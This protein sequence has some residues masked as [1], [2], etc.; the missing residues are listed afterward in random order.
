MSKR[1]K[2]FRSLLALILVLASIL[3]YGTYALA[4]EEGLTEGQISTEDAQEILDDS[5]LVVTF[6]ELEALEALNQNNANQEQIEEIEDMCSRILYGDEAVE[7]AKKETEGKTKAL[8]KNLKDYVYLDFRIGSASRRYNWQVKSTQALTN[9]T[10]LKSRDRVFFNTNHQ[11]VLSAYLKGDSPY[12]AMPLSTTADAKALL[13]GYVLKNGDI[14]QMRIWSIGNGSTDFPGS[15]TDDSTLYINASGNA[16]SWKGAFTGKIPLTTA[17]QILTLNLNSSYVGQTLYGVCFRPVTKDGMVGDSSGY[18][19]RMNL[20]YI[21]VG[22]TKYKPVYIEYR[23]QGNVYFKNSDGSNLANEFCKGYIGYDE[24]P[25]PFNHGKSSTTTS[26][27]GWEIYEKNGSGTYE[28]QNVF[29]IDLTGYACEVD[30]Y[31]VLK[32]VQ[33]PS[34]KVSSSQSVS[35]DTTGEDKFVVSAAAVDS[36]DFTASGVGKP[37][38]ISIVLDRSARMETLYGTKEFTSKPSETEINNYMATLDK[39]KPEGY[40]RCRAW[41]QR[42]TR[43]SNTKDELGYIYTV[44]IRYYKNEWQAQILDD[45]NCKCNGSNVARREFGIYI[46]NSTELQ[47]CSHH[48]WVSIYEASNAF[49]ANRDEQ[50]NAFS[51]KPGFKEQFYIG[52]SYLGKVQDGLETF[53]AT[54]YNSSANLAK[55]TYHRVSIL[56]YGDTVYAKGYP[57]DNGNGGYP[58][59]TKELNVSLVMTAVNDANYESILE[60]I[61]NPYVYGRTNRIDWAMKVL[62]GTKGDK[63]SSL[64]LTRTNYLPNGANEGICLVVSY[65]PTLSTIGTDQFHADQAEAA[66]VAAEKVKNTYSTTIYSVSLGTGT[67]AGDAF[68]TAFH[69]EVTNNADNRKG[70]YANLFRLISSN[71]KNA[72]NFPNKTEASTTSKLTTAIGSINTTKGYYV[73]N[74]NVN[75]VINGIKSKWASTK[76]TMKASS[77]GGTG[78]LWL[79]E[80]FNREWKLDPDRDLVVYAE[81]H[82]GN[83]AYGTAVK[84]GTHPI[85]ATTATTISGNGY[86]LYVTPKANNEGFE[87][88]LQWTDAK[89]AYLRNSTL[90]TGTAAKAL[91]GTLDVSKGYKIRMD[92][93]ITV[94]RD[95]T[96]GGN[97]IPLNNSSTSGCYKAASGDTAKDTRFVSYAQLNANVPFSGETELS[98]CLKCYDYFMTMEEYMAV[99]GTAGTTATQNAISSAYGKLFEIAEVLKTTNDSGKS[100]LAYLGFN[101]QFQTSGGTDIYHVQAGK[102]ATSFGTNTDL[103]KTKSDVLKTDTIFKGVAT[104]DYDNGSTDSFGRTAY[105]DVSLNSTVNF[106]VPKIAVVDFDGKI[107]VDLENEAGVIDLTAS[108]TGKNGSFDLTNGIVTYDFRNTFGAVSEEKHMMSQIETIPYTVVP[109]N[110]TK[111]KQSTIARQI[112]VLPGNVMT[113]DDT[114]FGFFLRDYFDPDAT[115]ITEGKWVRLGSYDEKTQKADNSKVHGYDAAF[116]TVGDYHG[117]ST[118][119][120]V[121]KAVPEV[122]P[123]VFEFYGT[124]FELLSRTG[125]DTGTLVVEIFT[126]KA[127]GTY[128][129]AADMGYLVDT[130]LAGDT[131]L[132]QIPVV[133]FLSGKSTPAKYKVHVIPVYDLMFDHGKRGPLAV[134]EEQARAIAGFGEDV[135]FQYIPSASI[136]PETRGSFEPTGAYNV[137]VDGC[138]VYNSLAEDAQGIRDFV[139]S[140]AGECEANI[141]NINSQIV[142]V[143]T[144]VDWTTN[145]ANSG[146]LFIAAPQKEGS[147]VN[148]DT[149][150]GETVTNNDIGF[151]LGMDYTLNE[152]ADPNEDNKFYVRTKDSAYIYHGVYQTKIYYKISDTGRAMFFCTDGAGVPIR[153][154]DAEVRQYVG[155]GERVTY[156]SS[157][158]KALGPANEVYLSKDQGVA[159][160]VGSDGAK[161]FMSL[162]TVGGDKVT[163]Q[164]YNGTG[165]VDIEGLKDYCSDTEMYFDLTDYVLS[166]GTVMIKNFGSGILSLCNLKTASVSGTLEPVVSPE[167]IHVAVEAFDNER[168]LPVVDENV[169]IRHSLNLQSDISVN[170]VVPVSEVEGYDRYVMECTVAGET[171]LPEGEIRGSLIYFTVDGLAA[172]QMNEN[173]HSVLYLMKGEEEYVSV[174]DDYSIACYAYTTLNKAEASDT[175]KTLCANLLRYGSM[176]QIYKGYMTD[177]LADEELTEEQ[178]TYLTSLDTVAFGNNNALLG[179]VA[180]PAVLWHGKTMILDSNVTLVYV[181]DLKQYEG[182]IEDLSLRVSYEGIDGNP[183]NT[184]VKTLNVYDEENG[185]YSFKIDTLLAAELRTV[186]SAAVFAGEEQVSETLVYSADTYGNN[187]TGALLDLCKALFAYSDSA[188]A[189]FAN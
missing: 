80:E 64:T 31:F 7:K 36:V 156:Y 113:Y 89:K 95:N 57:F 46:W 180:T 2:L 128:A 169:V 67:P 72:K 48:K 173:I 163:V 178:K 164:A 63:E 3:P 21:Y 174:D 39:T 18:G 42:W 159:F 107:T 43:E 70:L 5:D 133:Q 189:Y 82:T 102:N 27:W 121:T 116:A 61:R 40:Y 20:D 29:K 179:D 168:N 129:A 10:Y 8:A 84:I 51:T 172:T 76:P 176:A 15:G 49:Y 141:L 81:P 177:A 144:K 125:P 77:N 143:N 127:D 186:V 98:E 134:T 130:Y 38:D 93:P 78:S 151:C 106:Y 45:A 99:H 110:P 124:G 105:T 56:S 79:Y 13:G 17:H 120:R 26:I 136:A 1:R 28:K 33:I 75:S 157:A 104:I 149:G 187:K 170:L 55:D 123:I 60:I 71:Y 150:S 183:V 97:N 139:Y 37:L 181:V 90:S 166:D 23:D 111:D 52:T 96:L 188:K 103:R 87:V 155:N 108:N 85:T 112:Y 161:V 14:A 88:S 68:D 47:Q 119:A 158:Y 114:M 94:N 16:G 182:K 83:G 171:F 86:K 91:S 145:E 66:I 131:T 35:V 153:L 152:E 184:E 101:L 92:I 65:H 122:A 185:R 58:A 11:G 140:L 167:V 175:I 132:Y 6:P 117:A 32:N 135:A 59:Q 19:Y 109:Q 4:V 34:A 162:K 165:F 138:R 73:N 146:M 100:R 147:D 22:P 154:T 62:A 148:G 53:L 25:F 118:V 54:L 41:S 142:D 137:Y 24:A 126:A 160:R 44:P 115:E 50:N 69:S 9:D 12:V 30:T 74:M